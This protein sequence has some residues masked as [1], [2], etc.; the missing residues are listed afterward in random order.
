MVIRRM[1][2]A[3]EVVDVL[4]LAV[5]EDLSVE[6]FHELVDADMRPSLRVGLDRHRLDARID[7]RPLPLPVGADAPR[8]R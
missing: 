5:V 6:R 7:R 1:K 2:G 8:G 4:D 3:L